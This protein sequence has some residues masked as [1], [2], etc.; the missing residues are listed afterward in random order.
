MTDYDVLREA[1]LAANLLLPES[2]L[3][4]LTFG[5]VSICDPS[6]KVMAIKPSGVDYTQL[7]AEDIVIVDLASG[8]TV[9]GEMRP[10]SD[11]PT[12][13][14]LYQLFAAA[15]A[16]VHTHSR[17]GLAAPLLRHEPIISTATCP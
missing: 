2:Q 1:C 8:D 7:K 13:R 10:S 14:R 16:I 12:H 5:N 11:T 15:G 9:A 17:R 6:R 3:V 4:D